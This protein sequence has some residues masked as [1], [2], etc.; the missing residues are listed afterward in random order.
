MIKYYDEVELVL[1]TPP[2]YYKV[3]R[4]HSDRTIVTRF[5]ATVECSGKPEEFLDRLLSQHLS[6]TGV[7]REKVSKPS[8]DEEKSFFTES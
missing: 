6:G 1:T 7:Q 2:P 4:T 3:T 5:C 8:P